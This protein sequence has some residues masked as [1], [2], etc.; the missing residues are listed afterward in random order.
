MCTGE[1][2]KAILGMWYTFN[3][4]E[5]IVMHDGEREAGKWN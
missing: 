1:E 3:A 5:G 2:R 4:Q